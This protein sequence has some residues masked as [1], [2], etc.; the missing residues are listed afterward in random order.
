LEGAG[1][2]A[3]VDGCGSLIFKRRRRFMGSKIVIVKM[4]ANIIKKTDVMII[5]VR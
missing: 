1:G 4:D 3:T 2:V 5:R